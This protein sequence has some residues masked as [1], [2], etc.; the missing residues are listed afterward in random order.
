MSRMPPVP[1]ASK[2]PY[3]PDGG[4]QASPRMS[5][6]SARQRLPWEDEDDIRPRVAGDDLGGA[7]P[8][9][10]DASGTWML[11]AFGAVTATIVWLAARQRSQAGR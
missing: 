7:V 3:G 9:R 2:P 6:S 10:G 8:A 4:A 1:A 5:S 11:L